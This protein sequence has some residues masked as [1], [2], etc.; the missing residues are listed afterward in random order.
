MGTGNICREAH[1]VQHVVCRLFSTART[2][3]TR[4]IVSN[5][6]IG[7]IGLAIGND[8]FLMMMQI[9]DAGQDVDTCKWVIWGVIVR[10]EISG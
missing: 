3:G 5:P 4:G 10:S 9:P 2:H 7:K 8:R 1:S 6:N